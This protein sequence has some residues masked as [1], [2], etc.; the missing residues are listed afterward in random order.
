M[1]RVGER[2]DSDHEQIKFGGGYDHC[3]V[4]N[5]S[6]EGSLDWV[7]KMLDPSSGRLFELATT[8]PAVQFYTGNFLDGTLAG[9]NGVVYNRR[10]G[11][12][13]EPEHYPDSPNQPQFPSVVLNPGEEYKTSTVW[14]FSISE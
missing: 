6:K 4:L 14:R 13:F 2:I 9:K 3:W 8:E 10:F 7:V 12:C 11:L 1:T 5:K